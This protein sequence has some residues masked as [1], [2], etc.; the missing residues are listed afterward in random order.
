MFPDLKSNKFFILLLLHILLVSSSPNVFCATSELI[1]AVPEKISKINPFQTHSTFG[2]NIVDIIFDQLANVDEKGN[3]ISDIADSWSISSDK[4]HWKFTLKKN[5]LFHDNHPMTTNDILFSISTY[6]LSSQENLIKSLL[7]NIKNITTPNEKEIVIDLYK[8]DNNLPKLLRLISIAP[9]HL[10]DIKGNPKDEKAYYNNPIGSGKYYI[11]SISE[12]AVILESFTFNDTD[13][14]KIKKIVI[15]TTDSEDESLTKFMRGDA[16]II[17]NRNSSDFSLVDNIPNSKI[18]DYDNHVLYA[19]FL[20]TKREIFRSKHTRQ[21]LNFAIN[22]K[23]IL[24][25]INIRSAM[26]TGNIEPPDTDRLNLTFGYN[27]SKAIELF[28]LDSWNLD[29]T[30]QML[31]KKNEIFEFELL[32]PEQDT[33]SEKIAQLLQRNF[34]RIGI[35]IILKPAAFTEISPKVFVHHDF[36][37]VLLPYTN[38][39]GIPHDYL[40]WNSETNNPYNFTSYS[41]PEINQYLN[42]AM[43]S[44]DEKT[45]QTAHEKFQKAFYDDP[46]VIFLFWKK[47]SFLVSKNIVGLNPSPLLLFKKL[48]EVEKLP[49]CSD[50]DSNILQII[51]SNIFNYFGDNEEKCVSTGI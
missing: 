2:A 40:Y 5:L 20:N 32:V 31:T 7:K 6:R 19:V 27:T 17:F 1:I 28:K 21:A 41:N 22:Q 47:A 39:L 3:I 29:S 34:E 33:L 35:K 13:N 26:K 4:L 18:F 36:D 12:E 30:K 37:A 25:L 15:E 45:V 44:P 11:T 43:Y 23:Q 24:E 48:H 14:S 51:W 16:D 49:L 46:P 42:E 50:N 8:P 38:V 9:S 10:F